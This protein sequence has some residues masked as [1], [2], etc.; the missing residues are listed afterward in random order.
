MTVSEDQTETDPEIE[1]SSRSSERSIEMGGR[2]EML[3][4]TQTGIATAKILVVRDG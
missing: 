4:R 3:Q 2:R 1:S